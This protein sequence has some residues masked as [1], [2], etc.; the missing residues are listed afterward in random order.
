[1]STIASTSPAIVDSPLHD[2][3]EPAARAACVVIGPIDAAGARCAASAPTAS[4]NAFTDDADVNVTEIGAVFGIQPRFSRRAVP[5][6]TDRYSHDALDHRAELL[7][8]VLQ[9][10]SR[11]L[12][13]RVQHARAARRRGD[14]A[15]ASSSASATNRSGAT[16]TARPRVEQ[17]GGRRGTNGGDL[18]A[19]ERAR[20]A[21]GRAQ[22]VPE[23]PHGVLAGER[24]P[25]R[26]PVAARAR[27]EAAPGSSGSMRV[28]GISITCAPAAASR[29]LSDAACDRARV[30]TI[31]LPNSGRVSNQA[32]SSR[33]ATTSPIIVITGADSP[34]CRNRRR[35]SVASVA[36]TV[37]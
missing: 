35:A 22:R 7:E 4:T 32:I 29:S 21:S 30:T 14:R 24:D 12:G 36:V 1:M 25:S 11:A 34:S 9:R 23:D 3:V 26:T 37:R 33:S 18:H 13:R 5:S 10:L 31:R 16:S 2:D 19:G 27:R 15:D 20:V 17:R 28:A 8:P 6:S